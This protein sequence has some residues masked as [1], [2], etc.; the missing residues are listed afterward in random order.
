MKTAQLQPI[1]KLTKKGGKRLA[2]QRDLSRKTANLCRRPQFCTSATNLSRRWTFKIFLAWMC[3]LAYSKCNHTALCRLP[4]NLCC[5]KISDSK[6]TAYC[7]RLAVN[8]QTWRKFVQP[9]SKFSPTCC[10]V[11]Q[12]CQK[13]AH[14]TTLCKPRAPWWLR[15]QQR[16][17]V[18]III[19]QAGKVAVQVSWRCV[20]ARIQPHFSPGF[21]SAH[22][23]WVKIQ[24]CE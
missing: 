19:L 16:S 5:N 2:L 17:L 7:C 24:I 11:V 8:Q 9:C 20:Q 23:V 18:A 13:C 14:P 10:R 4:L 1:G 15:C 12:N 22:P 3:V 21:T 6:P